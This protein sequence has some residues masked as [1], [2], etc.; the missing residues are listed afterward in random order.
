[1]VIHTPLS[2]DI[3]SEF[4]PGTQMSVRMPVIMAQAGPGEDASS[5]RDLLF[6]IDLVD[7]LSAGTGRFLEQG[8]VTL[9]RIEVRVYDLVPD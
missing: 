8:T 9:D 7:T 6:G 4:A 1:M 2:P 3:R 5:R